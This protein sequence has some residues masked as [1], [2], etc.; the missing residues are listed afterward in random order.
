MQINSGPHLADVEAGLQLRQ[1]QAVDLKKQ[2]GFDQRSG[3][4]INIQIG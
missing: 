4:P 1:Q 3:A 2:M